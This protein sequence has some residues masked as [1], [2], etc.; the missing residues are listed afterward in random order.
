MEWTEFVCTHF[1]YEKL[2]CRDALFFLCGF[3]A[4]QFNMVGKEDFVLFLSEYIG[5]VLLRILITEWGI[6]SVYYICMVFI[7]VYVYTV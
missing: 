6:L 7:M 2:M 1:R 3:D 5:D 4:H